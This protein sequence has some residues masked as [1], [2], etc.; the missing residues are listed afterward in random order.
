MNSYNNYG[1]RSNYNNSRHTKS[2]SEVSYTPEISSN[3]TLDFENITID[4]F[5][6]TPKEYAKICAT[7]QVIGGKPAKDANKGTQLR[8]FYDELVMWT[9]RSETD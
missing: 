7:K 5:S 2:S 8:R 3:T 4:L 1:N 9:E 6:T